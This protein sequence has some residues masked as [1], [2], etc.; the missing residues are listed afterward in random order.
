MENE[1]IK[2]FNK[3]KE[4]AQYA[5]LTHL[6]TEQIELEKKLEREK[7]NVHRNFLLRTIEENKV[8]I[9]K[10]K[11][12]LKILKSEEYKRLKLI[13]EEMAREDEMNRIE[14]RNKKIETQKQMQQQLK[15]QHK[16]T[17]DQYELDRL[18][19]LEQDKKN[20]LYDRREIRQ[21]QIRKQYMN[22]MLLNNQT[23][24]NNKIWKRDLD[25]KITNDDKAT[26]ERK[27][28]N[29]A[30]EETKENLDH[31]HNKV[32]Q[33]QELKS[34]MNVQNVEKQTKQDNN[35]K[36]EKKLL[37]DANK[38]DVFVDDIVKMKRE[39]LDKLREERPF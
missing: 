25:N 11:E 13:E 34:M 8:K 21:N 24:K 16:K 6:E 37:N 4:K 39:F 18:A 9:E 1:R 20:D 17:E 10:K 35:L 28:N 7:K 2:I 27:V 12:D 5:E 23:Q 31:K 15:D 19:Q 22:D 38:F 29:W 32:Q 33:M 3:E 30:F 26:I 36:M 14:Q